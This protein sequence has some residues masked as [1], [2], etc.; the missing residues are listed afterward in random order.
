[1][2]RPAAIAR[3]VRDE[4]PIG[5]NVMQPMIVSTIGVAALLVGVRMLSRSRSS[6]SHL[7]TI[8]GVLLALMGVVLFIDGLWSAGTLVGDDGSSIDRITGDDATS[9]P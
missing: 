2:G 6:R 5:G 1:M 7:R 3:S 9:Q 8:G 4:A